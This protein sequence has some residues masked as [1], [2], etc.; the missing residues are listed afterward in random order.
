[1]QHAPPLQQLADGEVAVAEPTNAIAAI[2]INRY[3]IKSP[4][5]FSSLAR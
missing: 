3:F 5:E 4:V 2:I 1:L